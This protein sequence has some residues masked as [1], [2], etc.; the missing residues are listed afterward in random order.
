MDRNDVYDRILELRKT[1]IQLRQRQYD[2]PNG[3]ERIITIDKLKAAEEELKILQSF[4][5]FQPE[6]NQTN[7]I[8]TL[9]SMRE[10]YQSIIGKLE[11]ENEYLRQQ[12][13]Q[14]I[15]EELQQENERLRQRIQE[16]ETEKLSKKLPKQSKEALQEALAALEQQLAD[17]KQLIKDLQQEE[18]DK[19]IERKPYKRMTGDDYTKYGEA[20]NKALI[21]EIFKL[22]RRRKEQEGELKQ[23]KASITRTRTKIKAWE[24]Y[25]A[26]QEEG[27]SSKKRAKIEC[28]VCSAPA[29]G[30]CPRCLGPTYCSKTCA[31]NDLAHK[32]DCTLTL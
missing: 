9:D 20:K 19:E 31:N 1:I 30:R 14:M 24:T 25:E 10:T 21:D 12:A 29:Q 2:L 8:E 3:L 17:K 18:L 15:P 26:K 5:P 4:P 11:Q 6:K 23:L 28:Q 22:Q 13:G 16:L 27:Q 32:M 7:F